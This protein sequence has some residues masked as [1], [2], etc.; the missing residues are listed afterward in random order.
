MSHCVIEGF[1]DELADR[2]LVLLLKEFMTKDPCGLDWW[3]VRQLHL[4]GTVETFLPV[5]TDI[6][7]T[8]WNTTSQKFIFSRAREPFGFIHHCS[9]NPIL[10]FSLDFGYNYKY[11]LH[12]PC[13]QS[14]LLIVPLQ[15]FWYHKP[16]CTLIK[17]NQWSSFQLLG[18]Q[19]II[20]EK[21][22]TIP[23]SNTSPSHH[24]SKHRFFCIFCNPCTIRCVLRDEFGSFEV[25]NRG[26][27]SIN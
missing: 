19:F 17:M 4:A 27:A 26:K 2:E 7:F 9:L 12:L 13:K 24:F 23:L 15:D 14:R 10:P 1:A 3:L 25:S 18:S 5:R 11:H 20:L 8:I 22:W 16:P 21:K 6:N